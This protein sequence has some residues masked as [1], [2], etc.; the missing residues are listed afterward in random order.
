MRR[1]IYILCFISIISLP[2][3]TQNQSENITLTTFYPAPYGVYKDLYVTRQVIGD[4]NDDGVVDRDDLPAVVPIVMPNNGGLLAV[5]G[6][7][8]VGVDRPVT[9]VHVSRQNDSAGEYVF[10]VRDSSNSGKY[11]LAVGN[12]SMIGFGVNV[13]NEQPRRR[14]DIFGDNG[15]R[16]EHSDLSDVNV[17]PL[18]GNKPDGK[19]GDILIDKSD[20]NKLKWL[21][22]ESVPDADPNLEK[23]AVWMT[24]KAGSK[25]YA[26][27]YYCGGQGGRLCIDAG[28]PQKYC[29]VGFKQVMPLGNW[30]YCHKEGSFVVKDYFY[31]PPGGGCRKH[32]GLE[33]IGEAYLCVPGGYIIEKK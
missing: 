23:P 32:M 13:F 19:P 10:G 4:V 5:S 25:G 16:I 6:R 30:G 18:V 28:E 15:M 2:G 20:K 1:I 31:R 26:F 14:L 27:T 3:F 7:V 33:N 29:P 17:F 22:Q 24:P 9:T 8:G 12:N 21:Y 11:A